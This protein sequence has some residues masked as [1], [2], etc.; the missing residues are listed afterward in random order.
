M[1]FLDGQCIK[2]YIFYCNRRIISIRRKAPDKLY[3]LKTI[4]IIIFA[5]ENYTET[6]TTD[7]QY[8]IKRQ[9]LKVIIQ[10]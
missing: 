1:H 8:I 5:N 4:K 7:F 9:F 3:Y 2:Q 10:E 6:V